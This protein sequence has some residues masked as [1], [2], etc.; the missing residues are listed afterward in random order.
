MVSFI[1][2]DRL[3]WWSRGES[4]PRPTQHR[5]HLYSIRAKPVE[6]R[7]RGAFAWFGTE[8]PSVQCHISRNLFVC[9]VS[10]ERP[11]SGKVI[12]RAT[13]S[14]RPTGDT[15]AVKLA[16]WKRT[17]GS[18]IATF[19]FCLGLWDTCPAHELSR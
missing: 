18:P 14:G 15:R 2:G 1:G 7:G 4:N 17:F 11:D 13:D 6:S 12:L 5:R 10:P 9:R 19:W 16:A 8:P 3:R